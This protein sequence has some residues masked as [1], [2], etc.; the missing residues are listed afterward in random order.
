MEKQS[1]L[2]DG[3]RIT[4]G[5][6]LFPLNMPTLLLY[7]TATLHSTPRFV[8]TCPDHLLDRHPQEEPCSQQHTPPIL[9][10]MMKMQ[11]MP[12]SPHYYRPMLPL[13]TLT[14]TLP[15]ILLVLTWTMSIAPQRRFIPLPVTTT[16]IPALHLYLR[17]VLRLAFPTRLPRVLHTNLC[18]R[19]R[20]CLATSM[21]PL[22]LSRPC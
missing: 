7:P 16:T 12:L 5:Y 20:P 18:P 6:H 9:P 14:T 8:V 4:V 19:T 22:L 13:T 3:R 11:A 10:L 17:L 21:I 1:T 15:H 2:A